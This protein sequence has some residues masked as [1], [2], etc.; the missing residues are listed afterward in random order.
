[1]PAGSATLLNIG[2]SPLNNIVYVHPDATTAKPSDVTVKYM[3][4]ASPGK[5]GTG[6]LTTKDT[7]SNSVMNSLILAA[8]NKVK[9]IIF[10]FIGGEL[11][12]KELERVENEAGRI[13]NKNRHAE[14]LIKG[15]VDFYDFTVPNGLTNTVK[16]IYFCP[17]GDDERN[18]LLD[19]K[20]KASATNKY[21]DVVLQISKG[22][23]NLIEETINL[24][25]N[26]TPVNAIVNAANVELLFGSGI[27]SMCYAAI[28]ENRSKQTE[29]YGIRDMFIKAF[30]QYIKQKNSE[31][32][33]SGT[34]SLLKKI[35]ES[36][37]MKLE[38]PGG[39][40][41]VTSDIYDFYNME[42]KN[43]FVN[44]KVTDLKWNNFYNTKESGSFIK[45]ITL[46][47]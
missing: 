25:H 38:A 2:D 32:G 7:L 44:N 19:A 21:L 45:Y 17:W 37:I 31:S 11:F 28:G 46:N 42:E 36:G 29:L 3:I 20:H 24:V 22:K 12:F 33:A 4:Q 13:H 8:I 34:L 27:S 5:S 43:K 6:K 47:I 39:Y 14:M 30:K 16:K 40:V 23:T 1:M 35:D 26:G 10:P 15:V 9:F 18:A 41:T